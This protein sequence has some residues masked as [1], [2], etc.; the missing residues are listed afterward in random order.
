M[1]VNTPSTAVPVAGTRLSMEFGAAGPRP[2]AMPPE[3]AA[4][5]VDAWK[6]VPLADP[7]PA[8]EA[9]VE[10]I[11]RETRAAEAPARGGEAPGSVDVAGPILRRLRDYR[12]Y[13]MAARRRGVEGDVVVRFALRAD[14]SLVAEPTVSGEAHP[15]LARAAVESVVAAAPF[16]VPEGVRA[17]SEFVVTIAY[18]LSD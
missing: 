17:D 3:K 11:R 6:P 14:G 7:A 1:L 18:R 16:P 10:E 12:V 4:P 8:D 5:P 13:P 9:D 15:L 2:A